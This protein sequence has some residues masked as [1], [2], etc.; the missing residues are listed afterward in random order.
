M[1][2]R[3]ADLLMRALVC[4]LLNTGGT[5]VITEAEINVDKT[6]GVMEEPGKLTIIVEKDTTLTKH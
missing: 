6:V 3:E 4:H 5:C 2:D 1:G